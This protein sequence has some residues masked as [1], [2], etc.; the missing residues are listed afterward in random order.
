M[1]RDDLQKRLAELAQMEHNKL[2]ELATIRGAIGEIG[3]ILAEM[4]T[5][6]KPILERITQV[7]H[8][9]TVNAT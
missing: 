1:N 6:D 3:R 4:E 5:R 7:E 8:V 2:I 9:E